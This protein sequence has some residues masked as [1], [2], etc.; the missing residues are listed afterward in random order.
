MKRSKLSSK[1]ME[2]V[3]VTVTCPADQPYALGGGYSND[4]TAAEPAVID[5][6]TAATT[7]QADGWTVESE[8]A[9]TAPTVTAY[10]ICAK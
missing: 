4:A 7:S 3:T 6:P 1:G 9:G 8:G 2:G 5:E 10:A